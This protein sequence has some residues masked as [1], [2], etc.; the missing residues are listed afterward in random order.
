V[1]VAQQ[2]DLC[3]AL[4]AL[5][6]VSGLK[7]AEMAELLNVTAQHYSRVERGTKPLLE[8]VYEPIRALHSSGRLQGDLNR[9][10]EAWLEAKSHARAAKLRASQP[11]WA[12]L[13]ILG[14]EERLVDGYREVIDRQREMMH[15]PL[16]WSLSCQIL[17]RALGALGDPG[18]DPDAVS[19]EEL[20][21]IRLFLD[22]FRRHSNNLL[23]AR[24]PIKAGGENLYERAT[25]KYQAILCLL[26]RHFGARVAHFVTP[27][28]GKSDI[29]EIP[30]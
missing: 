2:L 30:F 19:D 7:Q 14:L 5:R 17:D 8:S 26:E 24:W 9:L 4:K 27:T 16:L 11:A 15:Q 10:E 6:L 25:Q 3:N 21:K 23:A 29:D 20:E 1:S 22:R 28:S 12:I 13:E 18:L